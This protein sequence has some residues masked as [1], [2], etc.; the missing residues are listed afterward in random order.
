MT[1]RPPFERAAP[2]DVII[3]HARD[4]IMWP[5]EHESRVPADLKRIVLRCLAKRPPDRFQ[6]VDS[7]ER[8]LAECA[9]ADEWTQ[10]HAARWWHENDETGVAQRGTHVLVL[11]PWDAARWLART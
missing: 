2:I 6:D 5:P 9:A 3:A 1:G 8:A 7:L 10:W 11:T 4:E